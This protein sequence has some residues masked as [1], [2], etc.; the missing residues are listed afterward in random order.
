MNAH[1]HLCSGFCS[2]KQHILQE[3]QVGTDGKETFYI[4]SATSPLAGIRH[5]EMCPQ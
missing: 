4:F 1:F 5:I 2:L 3:L